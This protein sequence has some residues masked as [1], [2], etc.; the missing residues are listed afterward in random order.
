MKNKTII[1]LMSILGFV[2]ISF[3]Q[4]EFKDT[5]E[6]YD[7]WAK[8][9]VIEVVYAYM[10][11]YEAVRVTLNP[12]ETLGKNDFRESFISSIKDDD[13]FAIN[14]KF[15][16]ISSF[17]INSKY[18]WKGCDKTVFQ[19]LKKQVENSAD[20]ESLFRLERKNKDGNAIPIDFIGDKLN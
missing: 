17:L 8:R 18:D 16:T 9:G 10:E 3:A 12:K 13:I 1:I 4:P 2:Q 11:D 20:L 15:N 7:Y 5:T 14:T 19:P 6:I